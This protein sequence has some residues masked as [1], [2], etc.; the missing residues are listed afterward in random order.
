MQ[1]QQQPAPTAA[2]EHTPL[3]DAPAAHDTSALLHPAELQH[4]QAPAEPLFAAATKS[5]LTS[6]QL[7]SMT[8]L[9]AGIQFVWTVELGYGTPYL[10]SLGLSK[11]LMTL[12]WMAGPLS[13]LLIQPVIGRFSDRC[14]S[15]LGRR[16]PFILGGAAFVVASVVTI[17]YAKEIAT[18]LARVLMISGSSEPGS[19]FQF[20]VTRASIV[21]AV[22]GFYVLDF[23]INA[24]QACAR[25][26]ALD[27]PPLH[28][29]DLANAYAGRMLNLGGV[30]GYMVGFMDLRALLPWQTDS[31]MQALCLIATIV[32]AL[33]ITWTC[34]SVREVPLSADSANIESAE[35]SRCDTSSSDGESNGG[36]AQLLGEWSS[37][38]A[39]IARGVAKLPTPVQR[40]CNVQFF[41]WV[42]W[43]PFL[44][45]AT[46]W[47]TEVMA[48]TGDTT[49]PEFV[50]RATRAG[51]FA[52]FLYSIASLMF[53]MVLPAF[54]R[55]DE[56]PSAFKVS[57]RTMWRISLAAMCM[58]LLSTYFVAD[59][60]GAT[61]L[62]ISM[63]FPWSLAMWAPFALVGEYVAIA[64]GHESESGGESGGDGCV[65]ANSKLAAI[66]N[67]KYGSCD[68][69]E[70]LL[71]GKNVC[72]EQQQ[73]QQYIVYNGASSVDDDEEEDDEGEEFIIGSSSASAKWASIVPSSLGNETAGHGRR[74][75]GSTVASSWRRPHELSGQLATAHRALSGR[76][77]SIASTIHDDEMQAGAATSP[78]SSPSSLFPPNTKQPTAFFKTPLR[79][80]KSN[81]SG[82]SPRESGGA[83]R[84]QSHEVEAPARER[85]ESGTI[86]GIHN[87]YVVLPQFVI[88]AVSS[89]VFAWLGS[90]G[91]AHG[92]KVLRS[93]EF[94]A[95]DAVYHSVL[96]GGKEAVG[97]VLRIG[98]VSALVA[99]ALTVF[100]YDRQRV[101][102]Y[103][104]EERL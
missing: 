83:A 26:L 60:R 69:G 35:G 12:V 97:W 42:A 6:W 73:Q 102:A 15:K 71:L 90:G 1:P 20:F 77:D 44:F 28:Q 40:V 91:G 59:V 100:L 25:A 75:I 57:L 81:S 22:I 48:R 29:Q 61:I 21:L 79:L 9:L 67:G 4:R 10:L 101:R 82:K 32:F 56:S 80:A 31:Q 38:F 36:D 86:L 16:R 55:D 104:A 14:A 45:F 34:I 72:D 66:G 49:D 51:S 54:I 3:L 47:V 39:T 103:I 5:P 13:G 52:L 98:G 70:D 84:R 24:S 99:A 65:S 76:G 78:A 7:L 43:F 58:T 37:M 27:I 87:M 64:T 92:V 89:L 17:A 95:M 85:L 88:N 30:T 50:E 62:I 63:A 2:V 68:D 18:A 33:T 93:V 11:P 94:L 23:S 96:G 41:A 8:V 53:S 46:T 74:S 19:D